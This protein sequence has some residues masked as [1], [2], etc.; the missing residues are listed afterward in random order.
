MDKK[1]LIKATLF[2][3]ISFLVILTLMTVILGILNTG[4]KPAELSDAA[5]GRQ[6]PASQTDSLMTNDAVSDTPAA[7]PAEETVKIPEAEPQTTAVP[8]KELQQLDSLNALLTKIREENQLL[9]Q[10]LSKREEDAQDQQEKDTRRRE[11]A[12]QM[13]KIYEVMDADQA[14]DILNGLNP[15]EVALIIASMR[16]RQAAKILAA[17]E[18]NFAVTISQKIASF[19]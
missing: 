10:S 11:A 16:Q 13:A 3:T 4:G 9:K 17:L 6:T 1:N 14:A 18:P 19:N 5:A 8:Q 15:Q 2:F 12:K 7:H